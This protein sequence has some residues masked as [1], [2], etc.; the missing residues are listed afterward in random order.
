MKEWYKYWCQVLEVMIVINFF[1]YILGVRTFKEDVLYVLPL[2]VTNTTHIC[3]AH[4]SFEKHKGGGK[5][6][7]GYKPKEG[8]YLIY[9]WDFPYPSKV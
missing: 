2:F 7:M 5:I 9:C 4:V 1:P 6:F 8:F 3:I